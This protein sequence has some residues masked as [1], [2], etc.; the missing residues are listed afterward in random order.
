MNFR[1]LYTAR[2]W[3]TISGV[4]VERRDQVLT[5][6]RSRA[7]FICSIFLSRWASMKGP[8]LSDRAIYFRLLTMNDWVRLFLRV[9]APLVGLPH[10]VTGWRPPEVLPSPPPCGWSIGFIDTPRLCGRRPS[11]RLRPAFPIETFLWSMLPIWPTVARHTRCTW[12][13]SPL[14]S[15]ICANSPSF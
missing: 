4:I 2:V 8:F 10:G 14:G 13:T 11:Q 7:S 1:P 9:L 15:L 5:T 3:P 12:R 6:L